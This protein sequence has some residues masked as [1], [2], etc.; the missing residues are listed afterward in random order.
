MKKITIKMDNNTN[1]ILLT[2]SGNVN[3]LKQNILNNL[4]LK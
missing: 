2:I 4:L 3:I 1:D